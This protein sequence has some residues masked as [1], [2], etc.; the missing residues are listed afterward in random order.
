VSTI[1]TFRPTIAGSGWMYCYVFSHDRI[2][3]FDDRIVKFH[4]R[5]VKA[6]DRHVKPG[7]WL[8]ICVIIRG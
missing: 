6:D 7:D 1:A 8:V 5:F 2:V 4:D 3:P